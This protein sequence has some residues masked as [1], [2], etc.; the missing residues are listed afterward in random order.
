M[1]FFHD[2][3]HFVVRTISKGTLPIGEFLNLARRKKQR[4]AT[5]VAITAGLSHQAVNSLEL[6]KS[7]SLSAFFIALDELGYD[8]FI[9]K[10]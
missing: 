4:S 8:V 10:R 2:G 1:K 9:E 5:E 3:E 6:G 7:Q